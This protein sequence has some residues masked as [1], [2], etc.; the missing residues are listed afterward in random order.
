MEVGTKALTKGDKGDAEDMFQKSYQ[1]YSLF[2]GLNLGVVQTKDI[3]HT[4]SAKIEFIS[5][6]PKPVVRGSVGVF[7]KLGQLV[8]KA[9][10]CCKE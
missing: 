3:K 2:W 9:I 6:D 1:L 5:E 10:D 7:E 4:E 8:Q